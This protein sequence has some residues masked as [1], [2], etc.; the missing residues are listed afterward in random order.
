[1]RYVILV[2]C[3]MALPF[4]ANADLVKWL[5][6][7]KIIGWAERVYVYDTNMVMKARLDTGA[8]LSSI[9]SNTI[10]ILDGKKKND[11]KRIVFEIINE[12]GEKQKIERPL[13]RWANIKKKGTAGWIKRPVVH[14]K[15]CI[16]DR[17]TEGEVTLANR[18]RFIY[19]LLIGR[20]ILKQENMIVDSKERY[21]HSAECPKG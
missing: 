18:S 6:G 2:L 9:H 3:L 7:K 21:T 11:P 8:L 17:I 13:V 14:L 12:N 1:M 10:E 4:S 15:L 19:P 16:A 20:N 5:T